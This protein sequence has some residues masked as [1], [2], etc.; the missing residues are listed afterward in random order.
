MA[1]PTHLALTLFLLLV[2]LPCSLAASAPGSAS[3]VTDLSVSLMVASSEQRAAFQELSRRFEAENPGTRVHWIARDDAGYKAMLTHWLTDP[4]GPDVVYWHAGTRLR[5]I[6]EAGLLAP[7]DD[8][9]EE[10]GFNSA[11]TEAVRSKVSYRGSVYGMPYSYYQWGFYY[12]QSVFEELGLSVPETWNDLL[13]F[14]GEARARNIPPIVIGTKHDWMAAAWFDYIN[15]RLNGLDFHLEVVA[16]NAPFTSPGIRK[17]FE[18]WKA[19][20][21]ADCFLPTD[22]HS[23][24][25]WKD[26]LP[27]LYRRMAAITLMGNFLVPQLT[28][29]MHDDF[30]F[31]P[32]P[33]IDPD[34]GHYEEAPTDL[35]ALPLR[36]ADNPTA[37]AFITFMG[38]AEQQSFLNNRTGKI[39]THP[40]AEMAD[41]YFIRTG[42]RLL[43]EADGLT[44][45]FDRDAPRELSAPAMAE[46]NQFMGHRD[47]DRSIRILEAVRRALPPI[48]ALEP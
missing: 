37:R 10:Q 27:F 1:Y 18:H 48:P 6:A 5:Q 43:R 14:C 23:T 17:V 35:F 22:V 8:L 2:M 34:V 45:F 16:G 21:D 15:L 41:D 46:F 4:K 44:E 39:S 20:L 24:L 30:R 36:S 11:Y 7:L 38:Q 28:E 3:D 26:T 12:R 42:A 32:F 13:E 33:A 9:W 40:E 29:S 47:I 31:F 19:L 25:D